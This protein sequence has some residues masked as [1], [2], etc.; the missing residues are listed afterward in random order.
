MIS[1]RRIAKYAKQYLLWDDSNNAKLTIVGRCSKQVHIAQRGEVSSPK[2]TDTD[3]MNGR[4][5]LPKAT[6][7]H[8]RQSDQITNGTWNF[9]QRLESKNTIDDLYAGMDEKS[10]H[11]RQQLDEEVYRQPTR[12]PS[13]RIFQESTQLTNSTATSTS[14]S[15]SEDVHWI[16]AIQ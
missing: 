3:A 12:T 2:W 6:Q 11:Q 13:R 16:S 8:G 14:L 1:S 9:Q 7:Q 5:T 10:R 4:S 15:T